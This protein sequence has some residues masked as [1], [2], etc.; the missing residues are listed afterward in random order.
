VDWYANV[1]GIVWPLVEDLTS[2]DEDAMEVDAGNG[3][4]DDR[5]RD[6]ILSGAIEAL[7]RSF[8]TAN[9]K[10][11]EATIKFL[12]SLLIACEVRTSTVY[13]AS[14]EALQ[15]AFKKMDKEVGQGLEGER[16]K[17]E[18]KVQ[19]LLFRVN[20]YAALTEAVRL[21]RAKA[22]LAFASLDW[23]E[24][25]KVVLGTESR[26]DKDISVERAD[27]VKQILEQAKAK[28]Q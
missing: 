20:D 2:K 24:V 10:D 12:N 7:Q 15:E 18:A 1:S 27:A 28:I 23:P 22:I 6:I 21:K 9:S 14:F 25:V 17:F 8:S 5:T 26:L 3:K 4:N 13:A 11:G 19:D 16:V